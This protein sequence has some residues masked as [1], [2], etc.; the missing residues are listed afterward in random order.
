MQ[1]IKIVF[2]YPLCV[3]KN[4]KVY[5]DTHNFSNLFKNFLF[6]ANI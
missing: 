4:K 5:R 3:K 1:I 6:H 2:H